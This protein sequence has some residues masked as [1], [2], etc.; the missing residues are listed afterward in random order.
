MDQV[1]LDLGIEPD[2]AETGYLEKQQKGE[3]GGGGS[4]GQGEASPGVAGSSEGVAAS[5]RGV[6]RRYG[7]GI[8]DGDCGAAAEAENEVRQMLHL[9]HA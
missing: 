4:Q 9:A 6:D 1:L 8:E 7:D 3:D 2:L 5:G